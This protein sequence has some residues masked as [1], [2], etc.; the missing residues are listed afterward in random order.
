MLGSFGKQ[1]QSKLD[2]IVQMRLSNDGQ[3]IAILDI[4]NLCAVFRS[5]QPGQSLHGQ[6]PVAHHEFRRDTPTCF[7]V[8]SKAD[9]GNAFVLVAG[10]QDGTI[11][12]VLSRLKADGTPCFRRN[13]IL[14]DQEWIAGH[15][16]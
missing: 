13:K 15:P 12:Y 1:L 8:L 16:D 6:R 14:P 4:N 7:T 10:S 2:K 5:P 9:Q 3:Y 11:N